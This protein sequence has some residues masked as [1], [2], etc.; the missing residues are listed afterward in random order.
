M[1]NRTLSVVA[2]LAVVA[3][4]S[5]GPDTSDGL[6][7]DAGVV[8]DARSHRATFHLDRGERVFPE[9]EPPEFEVIPPIQCH[10]FVARP[11]PSLPTLLEAQLFR[12][13]RGRAAVRVRGVAT[14]HRIARI[15]AT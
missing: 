7:L 1:S 5:S 9:C 2:G 11:N 8:R 4:N 6:D 3:C 10:A 14:E 12:A 15:D 13:G